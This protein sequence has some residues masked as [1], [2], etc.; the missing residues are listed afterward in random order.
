[1]FSQLTQFSVKR[2]GKQA[3][4]FYLAWFVLALL[5]GMAVGLV[6][7]VAAPQ[8]TPEAG[9]SFGL[10][11]GAVVGVIYCVTIG[12]LVA[13]GRGILGE[14]KTILLIVGTAILAGLG[15][16]LLGLI[17]PAYLTTRGVSVSEPVVIEQPEPA[18]PTT[19]E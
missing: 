18:A 14:F 10:I 1:M 11:V 16:G 4:G 5:L 2:T 17:I 7:G 12:I 6:T 9:F 13:R 8:I 3:F 15:G 19:I